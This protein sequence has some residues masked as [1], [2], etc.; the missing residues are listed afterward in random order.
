MVSSSF[1]VSNILLEDLS[2]YRN[3]LILVTGHIFIVNHNI[4]HIVALYSFITHLELQHVHIKDITTL[5]V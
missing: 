5:D 1:H 4:N 2:M 3:F